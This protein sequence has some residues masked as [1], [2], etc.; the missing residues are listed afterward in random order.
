MDII[1]AR[2]LLLP[3]AIA[4]LD[5]QPYEPI[6]PAIMT[7]AR[8]HFLAVMNQLARCMAPDEV[9]L[10]VGTFQGGSLIGTLLDNEAR[11]VSV[12]NFC[13]FSDTNSLEKLEANIHSFGMC[14]RIQFYNVDFHEYFK[15]A[16]NLK[17]GLYYYDG[18]HDTKS[19]LE[20]LELG[21][22]FVVPDGLIVLDDL[23]YKNV[24]I[25]INQ[26]IGRHAEE[27]QIIFAANPP[28]DFDPDWW[29]GTIVLQKVSG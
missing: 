3:N 28:T 12:D 27:I 22:P 4:V 29:N 20:G 16:I 13:E 10:E 24:R 11:A 18:A 17:C 1:R 6:I 26:F 19:T 5:Q 15:N 23:Y 21:L 8:P 25:G 14:D 7:M 9:Y 2:N